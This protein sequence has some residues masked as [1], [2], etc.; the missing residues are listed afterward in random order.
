[1]SWI[2][3]VRVIEAIVLPELLVL[4]SVLLEAIGTKFFEG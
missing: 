1:M 2:P 4:P 3:L